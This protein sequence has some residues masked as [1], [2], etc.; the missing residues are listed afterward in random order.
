M[1]APA[2]REQRIAVILPAAYLGGTLRLV[3]NLVRH[4]ASRESTRVVFAVPAEHVATIEDELAALRADCPHVEV[5]GFRWRC[6]DRDAAVCCATAAGL[7]VGDYIS[8]TYQIPTDAGTSFSKALKF[9]TNMPAS[10]FA[11]SS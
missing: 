11:C 8:T 5:R 10:F 4:V 1:I 7:E 2:L 6:L 9:S 3:L